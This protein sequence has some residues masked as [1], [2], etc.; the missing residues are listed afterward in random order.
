MEI[1]NQDEFNQ[2]RLAYIK[3]MKDWIFIY[4]TDTIYGIGCDATNDELVK[5]IRDL[6]KSTQPFTVIAPSKKW[7]QDNCE[8]SDLVQEWME[9]LPGPY[10]L[11]IKLK[12][13]DCVAP[14]ILNGKT[15]LGI[16]IPENWFAKV[17]EELEVPVVTTS[18]NLS[19]ENFMTKIE[20]LDPDLKAGADI[21]IYEGEIMGKPSTLVIIDHEDVHIKER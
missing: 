12:N 10:T 11:I 5:K 9:N 13:L 7:I 2:K 21:I 4:P 19:G 16:R 8:T 6:K 3:K 17:V 18:A 1:I 20:D 15:T 14:S